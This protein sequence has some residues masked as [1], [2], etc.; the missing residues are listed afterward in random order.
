MSLSVWFTFHPILMLDWAEVVSHLFFNKTELTSNLSDKSTVATKKT[1][2]WF[3]AVFSSGSFIVDRRHDLMFF[4][5]FSTSSYV[6]ACGR[7]T[8]STWATLSLRNYT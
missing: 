7:T 5:V 1:N 3:G 8:R 4:F 2:Y 6:S